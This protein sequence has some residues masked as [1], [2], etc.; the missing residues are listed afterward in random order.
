MH[1]FSRAEC[2]S[3]VNNTLASPGYPNSYPGNIH[4]VYKV[5]IPHG[6]MLKIEFEQFELEQD[7]SCR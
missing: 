4:C 7:D 2:G 6:K 5:S 1:L 3:V